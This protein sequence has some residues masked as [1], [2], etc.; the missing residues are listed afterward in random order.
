M[1]QSSLFF[2][3]A[4]VK[5]SPVFVF[6]NPFEVYASLSWLGVENLSEYVAKIFFV[7]RKAYR[8]VSQVKPC[9]AYVY[10]ELTKHLFGE[11]DDVFFNRAK[12]SVCY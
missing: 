4:R 5:K 7:T 1:Y 9:T 6:L 3:V 8:S 2:E 10:V 12:V 11:G